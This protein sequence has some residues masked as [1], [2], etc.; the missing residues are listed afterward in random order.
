MPTNTDQEP[1]ELNR[2][3]F[4]IDNITQA[5]ATTPANGGGGNYN[6]VY[7][8]NGL[9]LER[10]LDGALLITPSPPKKKSKTGK[11]FEKQILKSYD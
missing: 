1:I 7:A 9:N 10:Y 3:R 6:A 11:D 2:F 5:T 4:F 8:L